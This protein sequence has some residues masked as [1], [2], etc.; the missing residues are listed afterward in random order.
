[1]DERVR[2][3]GDHLRVERGL[4]NHT[5][6]AYVSTVATFSEWVVREGVDVSEVRPIHLRSFL[7]HI[8]R[9]RAPATVA[10]HV[11][12]LRTFFRWLDREGI[13]HTSCVEHLR[14]P[15]AKGR[16]P[17][18]ISQ[19]E[20]SMLFANPNLVARTRVLLE[21]LYTGGLRIGEV[22]GMDR[23]DVNMLRA[24]VHVRQ[25][26]GGKPRIVPIGPAAVDAVRVWLA[27]R[28]D[29]QP[30][31]LLG[32]RGA[33]LDPR[34]ARNLVREAG[35]AVGIA[36]LHPHVLRHSFATHLLDEGADLRGIQEMLG[37][38][39]LGTTQ[40][41]THVSIARLREV[42][43]K[44]HPHASSSPLKRNTRESARS[45]DGKTTSG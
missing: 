1:M 36:D 18:V 5:H 13:A 16:L 32:A 35:L 10:R 25:G 23:T 19:R 12:A 39:S 44:A 26:K 33:R 42:Y 43:D 8:G 15:G 45:N 38:E 6:R 41:Y 3:F 34:V 7:A 28:E 9:G 4:S 40:R 37:H 22:C 27:E 24:T 17:R 21:L 20:A 30:A 14:P 31:L 2:L 11:A 29:A